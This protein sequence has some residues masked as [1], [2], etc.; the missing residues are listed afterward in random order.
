MGEFWDVLQCEIARR[1]PPVLVINSQFAAF[2]AK[3]SK[4]TAC[5]NKKL[6]KRFPK[7]FFQGV[8]LRL[9]F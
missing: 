1:K 7:T 2:A 8:S 9:W 6:K 3:C 4:S 5:E